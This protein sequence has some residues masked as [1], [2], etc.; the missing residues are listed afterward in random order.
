MAKRTRLN[1]ESAI[2]TLACLIRDIINKVV[3][4]SD[5]IEEEEFTIIRI[6]KKEK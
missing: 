3:Y 5:I 6:T 1:K 4:V 2:L